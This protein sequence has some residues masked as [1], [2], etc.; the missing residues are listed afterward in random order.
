MGFNER[1]GCAS[2]G[3]RPRGIR[4]RASAKWFAAKPAGALKDS[5]DGSFCIFGGSGGVRVFPVRVGAILAG[6]KAPAEKE[7]NA[8]GISGDFFRTNRDA[9]RDAAREAAQRFRR[10]QNAGPK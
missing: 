10:S 3:L 7:R 8:A 2:G 4:N 9:T 6:R 1:G 5:C